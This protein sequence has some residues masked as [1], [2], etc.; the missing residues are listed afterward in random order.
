MCHVMCS[1]CKAV[2]QNGLREKKN[3]VDQNNRYKKRLF[4]SHLI[5]VKRQRFLF[6]PCA[7][8]ISVFENRNTVL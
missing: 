5:A 1:S 2:C 7:T 8:A 3:K 4:L 6:G